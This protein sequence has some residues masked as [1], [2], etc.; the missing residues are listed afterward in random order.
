[1]I[2]L[3][4][5]MKWGTLTAGILLCVLTGVHAQQQKQTAGW[6]AAFNTFRIPDSKF[7][8]HLDAQLRS[9]DKFEALQTIIVRPGLNYHLRKNMVATV[10]YAWIRLR[11]LYNPA[12]GQNDYDYLSEH[13]IWEQFI[14]NHQVAFIPIQHRFRLEQ[15]FMPKSTVLEG[16]LKNDGF[17][18][19]HRFRYFLRG[20]IPVDG[21]KTFS[22]GLFVAAQNEI[23]LNY[24]DPTR[25]N[26]KVFDQNRAYL[27]LGYRVGPRFDVEGGYLNQFISGPGSARTTI[28][29]AQIATYLRL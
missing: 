23:F 16:D 18:L 24:G 9:T 5:L 17:D 2:Q 12:P 27:A 20:V 21:A 3:N 11:A 15:R 26:G 14:V 28:H 4:G 22:K 13:R 6:F 19:A 25:T 10:G 29:V 7:S 8:V 1:M